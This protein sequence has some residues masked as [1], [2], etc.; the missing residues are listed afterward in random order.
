MHD[1]VSWDRR[2]ILAPTGARVAD[3]VCK[4]RGARRLSNSITSKIRA[5]AQRLSRAEVADIIGQFLDGTGG[6]W[7]WDVS[8]SVRIADHELDALRLTCARLHE[9][10]HPR[11]YCGT[12]GFEVMRGLVTTLQTGLRPSSP[13]E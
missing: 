12:V 11:H 13:S 8:T 2:P 10:P 5:M 7:D 1:P 4:C 9:D 3:M 6:Q